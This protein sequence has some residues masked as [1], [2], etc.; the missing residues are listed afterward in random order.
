MKNWFLFFLLSVSYIAANAQV[1]GY[2]YLKPGKEVILKL[3]DHYGLPQGKIILNVMQT[4]ESSL[5]SF[6]I[7]TATYNQ[8]D[9]VVY[10]TW[11]LAKYS[12]GFL[13]IGMSNFVPEL[14]VNAKIKYSNKNNAWLIYPDRLTI[15]ASLPDG[16]LSTNYEVN[17][18]PSTSSLGIS[19]R[20]VIAKDTLNIAGKITEAYKISYK[21]NYVTRM[22]D[23]FTDDTI[24]V[25]EWFV[26]GFGIVKSQTK[27]GAM[28]IAG[29]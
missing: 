26:P 8:L 7:T 4:N 10:K 9:S 19:N 23:N 27:N 15:G 1:P 12:Q 2:Y 24:D 11:A 3:Y 13:Y 21:Y 28:Q 22:V 25:I 16:W 6:S 20:K 5:G 17:E 14:P 18:I 29:L